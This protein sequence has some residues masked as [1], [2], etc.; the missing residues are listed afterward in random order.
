VWDGHPLHYEHTLGDMRLCHLY[1]EHPIFGPG[2]GNK[3]FCQTEY[4][5]QVSNQ[6]ID[7]YKIWDDKQNLRAKEI[8]LQQVTYC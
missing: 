3:I 1:A 2:T 8:C 4:E 7:N 6:F 5:H